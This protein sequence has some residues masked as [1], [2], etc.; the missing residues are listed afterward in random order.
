VTDSPAK[1]DAG[2]CSPTSEGVDAVHHHSPSDA[3]SPLAAATDGLELAVLPGGA[4]T[5]GTDDPIA[6]DA[7]GERPAR[8]ETVEPFTI[9]T[10]TVT[11]EMFA[12]FVLETGHRTSAERQGWSFVF[13][14]LLPDAFGPTRG[15]AAAPWWRQ[16]VGARWDRPEGPGS[17]IDGRLDHPVVHVS[18]ADADAFCRWSGTRL[19]TEREWEYA[20]SGGLEGVRYPWGDDLLVDGRHMC[21]IWQGEFPATNTR[22]DGWLGTAP[23]RSFPPN[24]YGLYNVVGNVWEWCADP[25][26]PGPRDDGGDVAFVIR[27][28]SY[29]CHDSYCN[30]YRVSARSSNTRHSSTGNTGFRV[31]R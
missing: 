8:A 6:H 24:G 2:C 21:N 14:G 9:A 4:F 22:E 5:M 17:T 27:G 30:R 31:A 29:L 26:R 25:F 1:V 23:A 16:V 11:N 3:V 20:A 19:P 15:V 13:G 10:T 7:D 18:H 28:G 12:T